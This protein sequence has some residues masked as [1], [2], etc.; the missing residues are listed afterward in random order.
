MEHIFYS[1]SVQQSSTNWFNNNGCET[2][3]ETIVSVQG[4]ASQCRGQ[5]VSAG[6]ASQC[7][8][9]LNCAG[10]QLVSNG[11]QLVIQGQ[12]VSAGDS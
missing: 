10:Q 5:L 6:T 7:R 2:L 8:G 1:F 9:Q 11:G 12:L 4:T 3:Q